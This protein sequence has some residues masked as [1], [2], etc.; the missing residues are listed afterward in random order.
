M[1]VLSVE[2]FGRWCL[3]AYVVRLRF[4]IALGSLLV[5]LLGALQTVLWAASWTLAVLVLVVNVRDT[6]RR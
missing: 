1:I 6:V 4:V 2:A 3:L 5:L